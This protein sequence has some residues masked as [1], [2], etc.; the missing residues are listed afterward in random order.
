MKEYVVH[1]CDTN[2]TYGGHLCVH[3]NNEH[4]AVVRAM[5]LL[6]MGCNFY[7]VSVHERS[8]KDVY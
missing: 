8:N 3:A 2:D 4:E 6:K 5:K 1:W 7:L